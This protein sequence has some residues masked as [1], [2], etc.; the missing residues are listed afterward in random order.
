M[1]HLRKKVNICGNAIR[2]IINFKSM[3]LNFKY[4]RRFSGKNAA[5]CS[6]AYR[7]M[8]ALK[9]SPVLQVGKKLQ[10]NNRKKKA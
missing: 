6:N 3:E 7:N 4:Y 8:V 10:K 9:F 1:L 5:I 2:S